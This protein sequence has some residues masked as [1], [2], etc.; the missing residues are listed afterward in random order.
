MINF[1]KN[2]KFIVISV[3]V[4]AVGLVIAFTGGDDQSRYDYVEVEKKDLTQLVS[5]TGNIKPVNEVNLSFDRSGT[6]SRIYADVGGNVQRYQTIARLE[7]RGL[8]SQLSEAQASLQ[9]QIARLAEL[10]RGPT[11]YEINTK[12]SDVNETKQQLM[13][14]YEDIDTITQEAY[15]DAY[16]GLKN[17]IAALFDGS[18]DNYNYDVTFNVCD[19]EDQSIAEQ[20]RLN[21]EFSLDEWRQNKNIPD[22]ATNEELLSH[23]NMTLENLNEFDDFFSVVN[24]A[25]DSVCES[26]ESLASDYRESVSTAK[27]NILSAISEVKSLRQ[28]I[29]LKEKTLERKQRELEELKAG[30]SQEEIQAQEAAVSRASS[31]V[32]NIESQIDDG[33]ITA[34]FS[35]TVTK[36]DIEEGET[37]SSGNA[38]VSLISDNEFEIKA[39]IPEVD[40]SK[41]EIGDSATITLDAFDSDQEFSASVVKINPSET[42]VEGVTTYE[43]TLEF[44]KDYEGIKPGMSA[45]IDIQTG[46]RE[47]V[48]AVP[49]RAVVNS[50]G[51]KYVRVLTD[52]DNIKEVDVETGLLGSSGNVEI[53]SGLEGGER[54]VTFVR[55]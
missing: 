46:Q 34:P 48:F 1:V 30:T 51:R 27:N 44:D 47:N 12:E 50:D 39:N 28:D 14:A 41:V 36:V 52:E 19:S 20:E 22:D 38:V 17:K 43:T 25:L 3:V 32:E 35:G 26:D 40:I 8:N 49:Q 45:D 16:D 4:L 9:E 31:Q 13:N 33:L 21:I 53:T 18:R 10:T 11:T 29:S 15:N 55:D 5:V 24:D 37:V 23:L 54:V 2:K 6:V 42:V 7:N